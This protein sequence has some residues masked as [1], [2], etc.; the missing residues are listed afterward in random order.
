LHAR[1]KI[2]SSIRI[3]RNWWDNFSYQDYGPYCRRIW[4]LTW[5][6]RLQ[7][8]WLQEFGSRSTACICTPWKIASELEW[9]GRHNRYS[10]RTSKT[11]SRTEIEHRKYLRLFLRN[12]SLDRLTKRQNYNWNLRSMHF[13]NIVYVKPD[14]RP[15]SLLIHR[16]EQTSFMELEPLGSC[17]N[18]M[19]PSHRVYLRKYWRTCRFQFHLFWRNLWLNKWKLLI[20]LRGH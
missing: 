13:A 12:T 1:P 19:L 6:F 8:D 15:R 18:I 16:R 9:P 5:I 11:V 7:L 14:W 2:Q 17:T 20:Y 10:N 3:G 4:G